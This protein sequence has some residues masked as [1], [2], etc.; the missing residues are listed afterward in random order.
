MSTVLV[1]S[2]VIPPSRLPASID[3]FRDSR[4]SPPNPVH[5]NHRPVYL[6]PSD[7]TLA[8]S[9]ASYDA[10]RGLPLGVPFEFE[11]SVFTGT[12]LIRFRSVPSDNANSKSQQDYFHGR[13]R[14]M[15]IVSQG[16]FKKPT[17]MSDL[18]FGCTFSEPLAWRPPP[19]MQRILNA[20]FKRIAPSIKMDLSSQKPKVLGLYGGSVQTMSIDLPGEQPDITSVDIPEN[21]HRVFGGTGR[22]TNSPSERKKLLSSPEKASQHTYDTDHVYTFHT[23]DDSMDYGSYCLKLPVFGKLSFG[24]ALGRQPV[25]ISAVVKDGSPMYSFQVW[26]EDFC[27]DSV[28]ESIWA[29]SISQPQF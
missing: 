6:C 7:G 16:K 25:T 11:T 21:T 19:S 2:T 29:E 12:M 28:D 26:H 9:D 24:F 15:Q 17:K 3:Q 18:Y 4:Q 23:Y 5:W 20:A 13:R 22:W 8:R 27:R 14:V 1:Q 10:K